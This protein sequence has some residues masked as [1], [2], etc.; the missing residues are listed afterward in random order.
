MWHAPLPQLGHLCCVQAVGCER[1][2][3]LSTRP[4]SPPLPSGTERPEGK[5]PGTGW[6]KLKESQLNLPGTATSLC[7]YRVEG[8]EEEG[9][10]GPRYEGEEA[11]NRSGNIA[12]GRETSSSTGLGGA[13]QML[14][15]VGVRAPGAST[16]AETVGRPPSTSQDQQSA[17]TWLPSAAAPLLAAPRGDLGP[18]A[19]VVR[20]SD[21]TSAAGRTKLECLGGR[22]VPRCSIQGSSASA[23]SHSTVL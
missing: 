22:H 4:G 21:S 6:E 1:E 17:G 10:S 2:Q 20:G 19:C 14:P 16:L 11:L 18:R 23:K 5:A 8:F 3:L 12:G 9:H 7:K 15:D 13:P